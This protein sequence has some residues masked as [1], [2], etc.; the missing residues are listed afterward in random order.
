MENIID[1]HKKIINS[2]KLLNKSSE[3]LYSILETTG[4]AYSEHSQILQWI[5]HQ[6][7]LLDDAFKHLLRNNSYGT[8]FTNV[9]SVFEKYWILNLCMNGCLY[10]KYFKTRNKG[11]ATRLCARWKGDLHNF[12]ANNLSH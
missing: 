1:E 7:L 5:N 12:H 8:V 6:L 10:Y 3:S 4:I 9:R 2:I 11:I